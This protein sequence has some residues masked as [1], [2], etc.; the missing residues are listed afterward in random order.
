MRLI[1]FAFFV[2]LVLASAPAF[3]VQPD[4]VMKDPVLEARAR[5]LSGELRCL[6]HR[7]H[8]TDLL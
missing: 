7:F 5:A 1:R 2:L 6:V 4:E 8:E 3:A